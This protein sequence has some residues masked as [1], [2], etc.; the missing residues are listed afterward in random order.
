[1]GLTALKYR[2]FCPFSARMQVESAN[3]SNK[4]CE[5]GA[6]FLEFALFSLIEIHIL[7]QEEMMN[8]QFE[9]FLVLKHFC[10]ILGK[11]LFLI[12]ASCRERALWT[13][14]DV[15]TSNRP[16]N[17]MEWHAVGPQRAYKTFED[18][19]IVLLGSIVAE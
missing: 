14:T 5:D 18:N 3:F 6:F 15:Q 10:F 4:S 1:M 17:V 11:N 16:A 13:W 12:V 7:A 8:V 19:L 2:I 9:W